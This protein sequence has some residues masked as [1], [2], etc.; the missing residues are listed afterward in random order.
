M[1]RNNNHINKLEEILE[2]LDNDKLD[3]ARIDDI[4]DDLI[5]ML[6]IIKMKITWS[7]MSFMIN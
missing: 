5:I 1:E 3:P 6:K 4:K 7:M 2:N